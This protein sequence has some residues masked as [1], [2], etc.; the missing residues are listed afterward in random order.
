MEVRGLGTYSF[1]GLLEASFILQTGQHNEKHVEYFIRIVH[2]LLQKESAPTPI[3]KLQY[4]FIQAWQLLRGEKGEQGVQLRNPPN[5]RV[6]FRGQ[7]LFNF[8]NE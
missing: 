6:Y 4:Y 1:L 2:L 8:P 5:K 7:Y 3:W